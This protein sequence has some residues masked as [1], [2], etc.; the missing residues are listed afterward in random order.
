MKKQFI[1]QIYFSTQT[2]WFE[3]CNDSQ[4]EKKTLSAEPCIYLRAQTIM[5]EMLTSMM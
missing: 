2:I 3:I 1:Y 4:Q 5:N